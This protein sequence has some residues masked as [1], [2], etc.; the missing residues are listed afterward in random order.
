MICTNNKVDNVIVYDIM[1][2]L[3]YV[4]DNVFNSM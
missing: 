2:V 4:R 1:G 3:L